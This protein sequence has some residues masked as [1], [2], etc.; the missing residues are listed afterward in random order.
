MDIRKA[1]G[2]PGVAAALFT[3]LFLPLP[4]QAADIKENLSVRGF[5]TLDITHSDSDGAVLPALSDPPPQPNEGDTSID[6]SILGLQVDYAL[7]DNL[8]LTLQAVSSRLADGSYTPTLD[9]AYLNYDFGNNLHLRGGKMKLSIL[10]GTELR[11]VGFSRLW[12]RPL[13]PT[14]GAG[15]FD[16]Y[17]GAELVKGASVGSYNLRFQ[18]AYGKADHQKDFVD[19]RDVKLLSGRIERNESWVNL[20]LLHARY[21]AGRPRGDTISDNAELL[22]GAVEAEVP[23]GNAVINAGYA[24]GKSDVNPDER[25]GYLSLGYR[26]DRFTPYLLLTEH[27][28]IF[29][30]SPWAALSPPPPGAPPPPPG[31]PFPPPGMSQPPPLDG[32]RKTNI[33]ALGFRYD[34]GTTYAVKVQWDHWKSNDRSNQVRGTVARDGNLLTFAIEGTF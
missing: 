26:I 16:D 14:S 8:G 22:M 34:L 20:A 10:Q 6:G 4:S 30:A 19:N 7:S 24:Y 2:L 11:Y 28:M 12:V 32:A 23:L 5:Y 31:A 1:T 18:A 9:W 27:Q 33:V 3:S 25:L 13:V 29:D 17:A 15:G 21:K